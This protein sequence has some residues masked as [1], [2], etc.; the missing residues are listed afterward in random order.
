MD[1]FFPLVWKPD[2]KTNENMFSSAVH[3]L[4]SISYSHHLFEL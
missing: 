3:H 1:A 4:K 2:L